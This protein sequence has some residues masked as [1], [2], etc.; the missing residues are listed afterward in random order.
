MFT[1]SWSHGMASGIPFGLCLH[2]KSNRRS[3]VTDVRFSKDRW[4]VARD[5]ECEDAQHR[6]IV[7]MRMN[8]VIT[9]DVQALAVKSDQEV[10]FDQEASIADMKNTLTGELRSVEGS[11]SV[12]KE[13]LVR[14]SAANA[15]I[16]RSVWEMQSTMRTIVAYVEWVHSTTFDPDSAILTW[17]VEIVGHVVSR[18]RSEVSNVMT[19]CGRRKR[20]S[21]RK[22][23]VPKNELVTFV[24]MKKPKDKGEIQT[25]IGIVLGLVGRFEVVVWTIESVVKA[26]IVCR[27]PEEQRSDARY[28][29]SVRGVPWQQD[30]AETA[31]DELVSMTCVVIVQMTG[32]VMEPKEDKARWFCVKREVKLAKCGFSEDCEVCRGAASGDEALRPDGKEC[33]ERIRG[34]TKCDDAGQQRLR[35]AEERLP[36]AAP[37]ARAEV[38]REGQASQGLR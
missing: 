32:T 37:P 19:A 12:S 35:A 18:S 10:K 28:T 3:R 22:A 31:G 17:N 21:C 14:A 8:E 27:M 4:L 2:G 7:G 29:K 38:A 30:S 25:C 26:R 23:L 9:G 34:D 36:P 20:K 1:R 24:P 15:E 33:R 11:I 13:S 5:K 16:E 6:W